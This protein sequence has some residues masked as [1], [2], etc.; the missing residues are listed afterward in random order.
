MPFERTRF[1]SCEPPLDLSSN[2]LGSALLALQC[3]DSLISQLPKY[4][5]IHIVADADAVSLDVRVRRRTDPPIDYLL[6]P[7]VRMIRKLHFRVACRYRVRR[8]RAGTDSRPIF[9]RIRCSEC[10]A[11]ETS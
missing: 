2:P 11:N 7:L 5:A 8:P 4:I 1:A 3:D 6:H 10:L 9:F